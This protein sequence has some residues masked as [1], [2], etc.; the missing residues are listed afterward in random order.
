MHQRQP[1]ATGWYSRQLQTK[2][3]YDLVVV[4]GGI[5]GLA[6]AQVRDYVEFT[7]S[8]PYLLKSLV[9]LKR[10]SLTR[11]FLPQFFLLYKT[12]LPRVPVLTNDLKY[13]LA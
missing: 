9:L 4:G 7:L 6:V 1:Q 5:V 12:T 10:D 2:A 13:F 11:L 8:L 3:K